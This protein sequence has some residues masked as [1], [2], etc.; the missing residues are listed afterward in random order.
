[1][2]LSEL[3]DEMKRGLPHEEDFYDLHL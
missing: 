3:S 2:L 1:L